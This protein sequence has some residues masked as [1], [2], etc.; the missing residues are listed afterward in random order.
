MFR[1]SCLCSWCYWSLGEEFSIL[2]SHG[3]GVD[4]HE[5]LVVECE[6]DDLKEVAGPV[7]SENEPTVRTLVGEFGRC[8]REV[9]RVPDIFVGDSVLAS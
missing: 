7:W 5:T 1:G 6:D 8:Q 2:R 9:D 3:H 4:R